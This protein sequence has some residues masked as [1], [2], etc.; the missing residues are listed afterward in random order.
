VYY[1]YVLQSQKNFDI[2]VGSCEDIEVRLNR[3]NS[4]KVRSTKGYRPWKL[5]EI[6]HFSSHAEAVRHERFLKTGQQ[7]EILVQ[8]YRQ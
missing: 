2:Y 6:F 3:H 1:V 4:G 8:K 7:K 5:L